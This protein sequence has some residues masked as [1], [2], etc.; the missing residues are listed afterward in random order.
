MPLVPVNA[1]ECTALRRRCLE[2][3]SWVNLWK[4]IEEASRIFGPHHTTF[5]FPIHECCYVTDSFIKDRLMESM[6]RAEDLGLRGIVVCCNQIRSG[7]DWNTCSL[8]TERRKVLS[9]L[10]QIATRSRGNTWI[11]LE[12]LPIITRRGMSPLFCYPRDFRHVSDFGI[13]VAW[14]FGNYVR[15]LTTIGLLEPGSRAR[16]FIPNIQHCHFFDFTVLA[17]SI[18][19]W[20]F[21]AINCAGAST[22]VFDKVPPTQ[23]LLPE[24]IYREALQIIL[25]M[26]LDADLIFEPA[27]NLFHPG[28]AKEMLRWAKEVLRNS[29]TWEEQ[30]DLEPV[31]QPPQQS[32][33]R[34]SPY[35]N[36]PRQRVSG[37]R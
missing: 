7:K 13:G 8:E 36:A 17:K 26:D 11:A 32:I 5:H 30:V 15:T 1:V 12:N 14:D 18:V 35:F 27:P 25:N 28:V 9:V 19:H 23:G 24:S 34:R 33:P 31:W 37:L 29:S 20:H 2:D 21:S 3:R 4:N 10:A 22:C 16:V 6:Y